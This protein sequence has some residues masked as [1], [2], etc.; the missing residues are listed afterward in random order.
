MTNEHT[1]LEKYTSHTLFETVAKGLCV[2]GELET[3]QTATYWPQVPLTIAVL[4]S[5]SAGLH[6]RGSWG[7]KPSAG[8]WFSLPRTPT[9]WLQLTQAVCGTRLY[10]CLRPPASSG[11]RNC[12]EFS[13]SRWYLDIFDRMHQF[14][15]WRLGRRSVCYIYLTRAFFRFFGTIPIS[16]IVNYILPL[17]QL[18]GKVLSKME[19]YH[20]MQFSVMHKKPFFWGGGLTPFSEDKSVY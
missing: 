18:S 6:N 9:N 1:S 13:P 3:E 16:I 20:W 5:H 8:S 14:L 12:T 4:L 7:P 11:H 10:N 19:L 15:D 2:R 17:F